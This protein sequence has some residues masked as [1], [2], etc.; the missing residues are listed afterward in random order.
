MTTAGVRIYGKRDLHLE[1]FDLP[2]IK[3]GELLVKIVSD[4]LCMSS[5]KAAELGGDHK[6][7]PDDV[8]IHP[9]IIGHECCGVII[10]VGS[11]WKDRFHPG[12]KFALQPALTTSQNAIGYSFRYMG[13]NMLYGIIPEQYI[14]QDCV[15]PYEGEGFFGG[16]LAEP[17]SCVIGA[18]H[19]SYHTNK[20]S[21]IHKMGI[22]NGGKT[23]ILAG[24]G[25]MGLA[26][27]DYLIH[28]DHS[29]SLL[30]VTDIDRDRLDRAKSL[31]SP[32]SAKNCGT[33][34][35]YLDTGSAPEPVSKLRELS[36]GGFDDVFV[37]APISGVVEQA[38]AI[39]AYDGCLNF[40]AGPIDTGFSALCNFYNVHYNAA[41]IVGTSG[42]NT[43]DM[44][45]ALEMAARGKLNPAI[46][47]THIGGLDAAASAT[48]NLPNITGG[49][50]VI[51][52][53]ISLPL[54]AISD[55]SKIGT[56]LFSRLDEICAENGGLW[57]AEAEA[58]L[59]ENAPAFEL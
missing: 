50:K 48:L 24:A 1:S 9:T 3:D 29:P 51:Y 23:A 45:E 40:F 44:R 6:R 2:P 22:K 18:A 38:D 41:H 53:H 59:L 28:S 36:G 31:L 55:F 39:L 12:D 8:A 7:V 30:V 19:A 47:V 21:Y 10:E 27:T 37:F 43:D 15:L 11:H 14:E 58:Y 16:S 20:G 33:E 56:P 13:G 17:L 4:S 32:E 35:V 5:F 26:L 46:L 54:T 34:L 42:G 25:P 52:N 57:C 49:K